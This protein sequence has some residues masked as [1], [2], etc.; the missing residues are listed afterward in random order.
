MINPNI[1]ITD[2][3]ITDKSN[4]FNVKNIPNIDSNLFNC[5]IEET[6]KLIR[7]IFV[8]PKKVL[9]FR[10]DDLLIHIRSSDI[11]S[12]NPLFQAYYYLVKIYKMYFTIDHSL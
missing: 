10:D 7:E 11:F 8:Y 1:T 4:F 3:Y 5:N 12:Q 9:D 2:S 6:H